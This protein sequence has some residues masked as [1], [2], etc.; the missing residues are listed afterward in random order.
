MTS[1]I[2]AA[3]VVLLG[4]QEPRIRQV[5]EYVDSSGPE[6]IELAERAGLELDAWQQLVLTDML[7]ER[8][9]G[10]WASFEFGLTVGRQNGKGSVLEARELAGLFLLDEKLIIHSAHEQATSSEHFRRLLNL[11]EGVPEFDQ[12]VLKAPKGKGAEAIELRGGQRIFFK[13]RTGGGGRGLTGDLV[14]LDED[15]ILAEEIMS[16]LG[17]TMA[18]RSILGNPQLLYTGSAIDQ[19]NRSH[20]GVVVSRLRSR[21][22][23]GV[24]RVGYV[25]WS[26]DVGGWL[27]AHGLRFDPDKPEID[28]VTPALLA[29]P[30]MWAQANPGM[31]IRISQEHIANEHGGMLSARGF[32]VERLSIG[33]W[34]DPS[35]AAGREISAEIWEDCLDPHSKAGKLRAFAV[36]VTPD[37]RYSAISVA[38]RRAD[39]KI[40]VETV[41]HERGT[42]WV[43]ARAVELGRK[44][45]API[46]LDE[47]G[48][49]AS[50]LPEFKEAGLEPVPPDTPSA[51][52]VTIGSGDFA[53]AYGVFVD[54]A[55]QRI[56]RHL[57]TP[58]LNTAVA[59]AVTRKIGEATGWSRRDSDVDI[60]P[61]V[62]GTIA[63]WLVSSMK[64]PKA[65]AI[66][67]NEV[68]RNLQARPDGA[69]T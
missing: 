14:V 40:H 46:G 39:G 32:A 41:E 26:A 43:V 59:G 35:E 57:G 45:K 48:P 23:A 3:P 55:T 65:R 49:A 19:E 8:P 31:E 44:Y 50:L 68:Y 58:E 29:D 60:S 16:T 42:G 52:L 2:A 38:S 12:R 11:I 66:D 53:K 21:A 61:L 6:A 47:R 17:P 28:Q 10:R 34:P 13:T 4:S 9:D 67:L 54:A 62:A 24:P 15:M 33:D 18:A 51:K 1:Q 20:D 64:P 30:E 5:P 56:L 27:T 37:R 63:T 69:V 36:E 7:G 25:E 22:L